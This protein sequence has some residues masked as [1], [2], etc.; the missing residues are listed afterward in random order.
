M[1]FSTTY[2]EIVDNERIV[3]SST[4][5]SGETM[6]TLS[7]TTVELASDGDGTTLTLTEHGAYLDGYEKPEWREEGTAS[8]LDSLAKILAG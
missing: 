4:M 2:A 3:Y 6:T 8:Q 5:H 7:L 1:T